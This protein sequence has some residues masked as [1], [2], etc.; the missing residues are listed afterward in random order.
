MVTPDYAIMKVY[1]S[2]MG[3]KSSQWGGEALKV[4][5][6]LELMSIGSN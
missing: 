5:M 3:V 6:G 1:A 2:L 4:F